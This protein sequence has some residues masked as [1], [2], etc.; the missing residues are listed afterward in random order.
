MELANVLVKL[1]VRSHPPDYQL[2]TDTDVEQNLNTQSRTRYG[3]IQKP[4]NGTVQRQL[5]K[6]LSTPR[7][8]INDFELQYFKLGNST[9]IHLEH[10]W[11]KFYL[12]LFLDW[13]ICLLVIGPLGVAYWRGTWNVTDYILDQIICGGSLLGGNILA[14]SLGLVGVVLGDFLHPRAKSLAGKPGTVLHTLVCRVFSVVWA[15]CNVLMWQGIWDGLNALDF[16]FCLFIFPFCMVVLT[17][18]GTCRSA[19][20]FPMGTSVDDP[21]RH[22][23]SSTLLDAQKTESLAYRL[24]DSILSRCIEI[25]VIGVWQGIWRLQDV[26]ISPSYLPLVQQETI[27]FSLSLGCM[28]SF[29]VFLLQFPLLRFCSNNKPGAWVLSVN[30]VYCQIAIFSTV[31]FFRSGWLVMD[32]FYLADNLCASYMTCMMFGL[33]GLLL[34]NCASSLHPGVAKDSSIQT[35]GVAIPFYYTSYFYIQ[36]LANHLE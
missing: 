7:L 23:S 12:L 3:S 33:G 22:I 13:L 31:S 20:S 30:W 28:G 6:Q 4:S 26:Y 1:W 36:D 21:S 16:E 27:F 34:L 11:S 14:S 18:T 32:A 25:C 10:S 35:T 2:I 15:L 8:L 19:I 5:K 24:L 9:K 29:L 17:L